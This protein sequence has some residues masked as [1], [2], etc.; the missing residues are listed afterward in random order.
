MKYL[1]FVKWLSKESRRRHPTYS[2]IAGRMGTN[3]GVVGWD[4]KRKRYAFRP[5]QGINC[6]ITLLREVADFIEEQGK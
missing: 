6:D 2:V 4:T 3:L 1:E 5:S